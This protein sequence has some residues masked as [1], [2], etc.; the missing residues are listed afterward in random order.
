MALFGKPLEQILAGIS[1]PYTDRIDGAADVPLMQQQAMQAPKKKGLF[2]NAF[3]S[4]SPLWHIMGGLGDV[5]TGEPVYTHGLQ[6]RGMLRQKSLMDQAQREADWQDWQRKKQ[7][8]LDNR[9]PVRND[10]IEDF[11]WFK[12]LPEEDRKLYQ[13]M[14]PVYRQG[15]DGQFYRVE[16]QDGGGSLGPELPPGWEIE[17]GPASAPGGFPR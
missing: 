5:I 2:G 4:D 8:E 6:Q 3:R 11:K 17:G 9:P 10:T 12:D 1:R 14:R 15:P 16:G 7:W 13:E